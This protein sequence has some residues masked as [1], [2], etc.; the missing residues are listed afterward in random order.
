MMYRVQLYGLI[1]SNKIRIQIGTEVITLTDNEYLAQGGEGVVYCKGNIAYKIYHDSDKM[2]PEQKIYELQALQI[3]NVLAPIDIIY[4]YNTKQAIGFTMPYITSTEY[5]SRLFVKSFKKQH[6]INPKMVISLV[7]KMQETL[8]E[9]HQKGIVVGD[10]NEM[11]FLVDNKF[12][13]IFHID[14]DSYQTENYPST[15]IMDSVRDR[16]VPIGTFNKETDWF[17]WAIVTFQLYTGIHPFKGRHPK[18]KNNDIDS[19]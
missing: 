17:S 1:V 19:R 11:N 8:H 2:I 5:L 13:N 15:A 16:Q 7:R 3:S 18:Y 6:S 9:I 12:E 10:Y 14:V 4:N